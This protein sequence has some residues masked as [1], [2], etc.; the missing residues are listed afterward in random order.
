MKMKK[1]LLVA[2]ALLF[3]TPA[4]YGAFGFYGW[5]D[6]GT[7]LGQYLDIDATNVGAPAPV[8]EGERSLYLVDQTA[9][10]T[11][12]AYVA[13]IDGLLDNDVID[14]CFARYDD[15]PGVAPSL[16]IWGHYTAA[17]GTIEDY[18]TSASGNS[19]YG[20]GLGWDQACY[21]WIFD[22]NG[23][24]RGGLVVEAR[25][26][27][28]PGDWGYVDAIEVNYPDHATVTFPAGAS[29]VESATWSTIKSL[30]R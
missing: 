16:R 24:E 11:P 25:T 29:P 22:S 26:Y 8:F 10:G 18:V 5:E 14:V 2:L 7:I 17:G 9:S 30:Y 27:S 1:L 21:Q 6:G 19:D 3:V 13:W 15:T 23:G 4:A 20:P 12:Q 28:N